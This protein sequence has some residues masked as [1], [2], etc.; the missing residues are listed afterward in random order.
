[1]VF[2]ASIPVIL[3]PFISDIYWLKDMLAKNIF[4]FINRLLFYFVPKKTGLNKLNLT[5]G[6]LSFQLILP[7]QTNERRSSLNKGGFLTNS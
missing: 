5:P 3:L 4:F 2:S 7:S 6:Y 1:V